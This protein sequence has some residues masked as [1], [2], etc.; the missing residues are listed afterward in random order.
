MAHSTPPPTEGRPAARRY[1]QLMRASLYEPEEDLDMYSNYS[2]YALPLVESTSRTGS[3][4]SLHRLSLHLH[5]LSAPPPILTPLEADYEGLSGMSAGFRHSTTSGNSS[6]YHPQTHPFDMPYRRDSNG[7]SI[8][9]RPVST[10][11]RPSLVST[12]SD[13]HFVPLSYPVAI[14]PTPSS[15][16]PGVATAAGRTN[17]NTN[18][19]TVPSPG[20]P[21]FPLNG[22]SFYHTSPSTPSGSPSPAPSASMIRKASSRTNTPQ[23]GGVGP[24]GSADPNFSKGPHDRPPSTSSHRDS[25]K[26]FLQRSKSALGRM[27]VDSGDISGS[28]SGENS[29]QLP[30]STSGAPFLPGGSHPP[31]GTL[32]TGTPFDDNDGDAEELRSNSVLTGLDTTATGGGGSG[33]AGDVGFGTVGR[34]GGRLMMDDSVSEQQQQ[35]DHQQQ[36]QQQQHRRLSGSSTSGTSNDNTS[37]NETVT[38][39]GDGGGRRGSGDDEDVFKMEAGLRKASLA[40]G[41]SLSLF[42][43]LTRRL[44]R[45]I[46]TDDE[47]DDERTESG[48]GTVRADHCQGGRGEDGGG[49]EGGRGG[50]QSL[51]HP[52]PH[53][54]AQRSQCSNPSLVIQSTSGPDDFEIPAMLQQFPAYL[55]QPPPFLIPGAIGGGGGVVLDPG[56]AVMADGSPGGYYI[57]SRQEEA[58]RLLAHDHEHLR[59]RRWRTWNWSKATLAFANTVLLGYSVLCTMIMVKSWLGDP[60]IK[61]LLDSGIMMIANRKLLYLTTI[62]YISFRRGHVTLY[63]KLK[64]SWI[65]EYDRNDRLVIQNAYQEDLLGNTSTSAFTLVAIQLF[66][67]LVALMCSNHVDRLFR[68]AKEHIR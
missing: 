46:A 9:Q 53:L 14:R 45:P 43:K 40:S 13:D 63:A 44:S 50:A 18:T 1:S 21:L 31:T 61:P 64:Y 58:R 67:I 38:A 34:H 24:A 11:Q 6:P 16:L 51:L 23:P 7:G 48:R 52:Q 36:Q 15:L 49:G 27:H 65:F 10:T 22:G 66:V 56:R 17:T 35:C 37:D 42:A 29:D 5:P 41:S 25:V 32:R 4:A 19:N 2:P 68:V 54:Q 28:S 47:N 60:A 3:P 20:P 55:F 59:G 33:S 8:H 26:R 12:P 62:G 57:L 39:G 30:T